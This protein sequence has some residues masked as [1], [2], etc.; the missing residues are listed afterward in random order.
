MFILQSSEQE[1]KNPLYVCNMKRQ[2]DVRDSDSWKSEGLPE[3]KDFVH[4]MRRDTKCYAWSVTLL[5]D[6]YVFFSATQ[7]ILNDI[8][9][10][11]VLGNSTFTVDTRFELTDGLRLCDS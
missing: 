8:M 4:Q 1:P 9:K 7:R 2:I 5:I 6:P 10:F 11:C 3:C